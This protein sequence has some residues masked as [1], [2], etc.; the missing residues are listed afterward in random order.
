MKWTKK[1]CYFCYRWPKQF[2][3][4]QKALNMPKSKEHYV[5][6]DSIPDCYQKMTDLAQR[7]NENDRADDEPLTLSTAALAPSPIKGRLATDQ[8]NRP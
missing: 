1:L 4:I 2:N 6:K 7:Q 3:V 8:A 5:L